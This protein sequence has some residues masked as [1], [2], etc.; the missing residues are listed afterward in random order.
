MSKLTARDWRTLIF[1]ELLDAKTEEDLE[2][3]ADLAGE[4]VTAGV[5]TQEEVDAI[6]DDFEPSIEN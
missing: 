2:D 1:N 6:W 4:A 3:V 5:L